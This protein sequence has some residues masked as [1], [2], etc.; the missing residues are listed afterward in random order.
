MAIFLH[1][2]IRKIEVLVWY[3]CDPSDSPME[4]RDELFACS[5]LRGLAHHPLNMVT[6]RKVFSDLFP[7]G[8]VPGLSD[9]EIIQHLAWRIVRGYI[10][11]VP[12]VSKLP[13]TGPGTPQE[14]PDQ[15][16]PAAT[17][18][19]EK[20]WIEIQLLDEADQPVARER[21]LIRR[22]DGIVV[23]QGYT[24]E[25]GLARADNLDPGTYQVSFTNLDEEAWELI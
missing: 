19:S 12:R 22:P 1:N 24:D 14:A 20:T 11:L 7:V 3:R 10:K 13:I 8:N 25:Q 23:S 2:G 17:E 6:L 9:D 21:F 5:F 18:A 15:E 16:E 4:F